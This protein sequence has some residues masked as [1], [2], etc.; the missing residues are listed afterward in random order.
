MV[1]SLLWIKL[2]LY[3]EEEIMNYRL[4]KYKAEYSYAFLERKDTIMSINWEISQ[5]CAFRLFKRL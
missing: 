2:S 5:S 1:G 4:F 3:I